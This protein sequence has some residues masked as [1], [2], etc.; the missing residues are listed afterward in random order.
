MTYIK[1]ESKIGYDR[2][3]ED[4]VFPSGTRCVEMVDYIGTGVLNE[5][6]EV[7]GDEPGNS[8]LVY[9]CRA[10]S[11]YRCFANATF[12][13]PCIVEIGE[14]PSQVYDENGEAI[15]TST[16]KRINMAAAFRNSDLEILPH[17]CSRY[18]I[19]NLNSTFEGCTK[20]K[21]WSPQS[22]VEVGLAGV[23]DPNAPRIV[24]SNGMAVSAFLY[25]LA[26]LTMKRMFAGCTSYDGLAINA[27][28][29]AKLKDENSAAG[30]AK[31]CT[32]APHFLNAIIARIHR[33]YFV[34]KQIRTPLLDVDL[35]SGYVT[36]ETAK[37]AKEL[38]AAGIE[39]TGF[40]ID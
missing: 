23:K 15:I 20:L 22:M 30:F 40:E 39:L 3:Y 8:Y 6:G 27:I 29:W 37:Q 7:V 10:E 11:F 31:G 4:K 13:G 2:R 38:I 35:G 34:K 18:L 1:A 16:T 12:G 9:Y 24:R 26:P 32:F 14:Y 36:G 17:G 5:K 25:N 33:Q 21:S 28:S 19:D